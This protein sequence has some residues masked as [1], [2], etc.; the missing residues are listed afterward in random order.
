M[1]E[2]MRAHDSTFVHSCT[3]HTEWHK[4]VTNRSQYDHHGVQK[5]NRH[6]FV[7]ILELITAIW[8]K[9]AKIYRISKRVSCCPR[10]ISLDRA[11]LIWIKSIN[12]CV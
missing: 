4:M 5:L 6:L 2:Q 12:Q 9:L 10:A 3:M 11:T 8:M 7:V 1:C